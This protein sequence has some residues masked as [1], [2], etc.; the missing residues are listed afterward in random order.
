MIGLV[1]IASTPR[2]VREDNGFTWEPI[3]EV[4]LPV[5]RHLRHH[6]PGARD[7]ARPART[8]SPRRAVVDGRHAS[9]GSTSGCRARCRASSTTRRPT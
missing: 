8:G 2:A 3:K 1:S 9:H 7:P 4:A 6:H 5:L